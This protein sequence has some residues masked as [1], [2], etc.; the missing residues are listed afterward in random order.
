MKIQIVPW[1]ASVV[2]LTGCSNEALQ[3]RVDGYND[4]YSNLQERREIR[5][6]ARD[7]RYDAWWNR[8]MD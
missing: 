7:A 2:F 8:V 3:K 5:Q 1:I 4:A 6:D